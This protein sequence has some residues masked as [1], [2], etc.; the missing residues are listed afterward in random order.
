[1]NAERDKQVSLSHSLTL[2]LSHSLT[3][4]LS[5]SLTVAFSHS[6]TLSLS[7][8]H[9]QVVIAYPDGISTM[10]LSIPTAALLET[11][12]LCPQPSTLKPKLS[13]YTEP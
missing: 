12:S 8:S 13:L 4:A 11:V 9:S 3:I 10:D 5:H 1:M 7:L 6:L 2:S